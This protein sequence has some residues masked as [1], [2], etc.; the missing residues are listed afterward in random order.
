MR[1]GRHNGGFMEAMNLE[2]PNGTKHYRLLYSRLGRFMQLP[3][4]SDEAKTKL[5]RVAKVY[6]NSNGVCVCHDFRTVRSP[7]P[8]VKVGDTLKIDVST[9]KAL[10]LLKFAIGS[11]VMVCKGDPHYV[12]RVGRVRLERKGLPM[13]LVEE[14]DGNTIEVPKSCVIVIG[15]TLPWMSLPKCR[16]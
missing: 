8:L 12:G 13:L 10:K 3:I 6:Q 14:A 2:Y 4:S 9:G 7:D 11:L 5:V 1:G 15:D 16:G